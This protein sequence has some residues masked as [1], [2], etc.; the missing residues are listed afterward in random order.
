MT[1]PHRFGL[2]ILKDRP[3]YLRI[4][5]MA[6]QTVVW[7]AWVV[8]IFFHDSRCFCFLFFVDF[9]RASLIDDHL[10]QSG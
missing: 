10:T 6:V 7:T 8:M 2:A 3:S 5:A 1:S 9:D 4:L